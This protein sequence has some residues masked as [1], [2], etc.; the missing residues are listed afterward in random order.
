MNLTRIKKISNLLSALLL[1]S[2][3]VLLLICSDPVRKG[4]RDGLKSCAVVLIPSLFPFMV[5][6]GILGESRAAESLQKILGPVMRRF[7]HLPACTACTVFMGLIG[8][9]PIGAKM[10][11]SLLEQKQIDSKTAVHLLCFCVNA[12][13]SF[14]ITAVGT[15]LMGNFYAGFLLLCCQWI[16]AI[17]IGL[18]LGFLNRGRVLVEERKRKK[19]SLP[20]SAALVQGVQS[21]IQGM[22]SVIGYVLLFSAIIELFF[23]FFGRENP[24]ILLIAGLL[25]VTTGC[26]HTAAGGDLVLIGFFVS[27]SGLSVFFQAISFFKEK[28]FSFFPFFLS[29]V[30][31]GM[32]TA[33]LVRI[34]ILLFPQTACTVFSNFSH[35]LIPA[36]SQTPTIAVLLIV[37]CA[38]FL[39]SLSA[40][41]Y[42]RLD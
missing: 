2:A 19:S 1:L 28:D 5:L 27:F 16:S 4:V 36:F 3:A 30:V 13:P 20:F 6:S 12:G 38:V 32:I 35:P 8:G 11:A 37:L 15:G 14:L 25:E 17:L 39:L 10:T 42:R 34:G 21:G 29:R 18:W 9:Y 33:I 26:I 22:L 23:T 31:H 40:R 41:N 24:L 7:F